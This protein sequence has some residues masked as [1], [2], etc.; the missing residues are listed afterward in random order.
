MTERQR[1]L[2][3]I[4]AREIFNEE[5][6]NIPEDITLFS[7]EELRNAH[8]YWTSCHNYCSATLATVQ[9][10]VKE[11]KRLREVRYKTLFLYNK[12]ERQSNDVARYNSELDSEVVGYDDRLNGL[13]QQEIIWVSLVK[14]CDYNRTLL[15]RDQSWRQDELTTYYHGRGGQ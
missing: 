9:Q 5:I 14:Q 12:Q 13:E 8:A 6:G 11:I 15:S 4:D 2:K 1:P 7:P 3:R 10:K